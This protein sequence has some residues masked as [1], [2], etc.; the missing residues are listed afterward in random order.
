VAGRGRGDGSAAG[1]VS[2]VG[3][4]VI[5][6][7]E[8]F[9][10]PELA[11][12]E[13]TYHKAPWVEG[14][15]DLGDM[16]LKRMDEAG[17]DL[18]VIS[19]APPAAQNLPPEQSVAA[20]RRANDMLHEAVKAHPK[21]FAGFAALPTPD[22]KAAADE[23]E[24]CV[25]K[26]GFKGAMTHGLTHGAFI[27][28][29]RFWPIFERAEALGVP[30]YLH[31]AIP[32]P[33]I[34]EIY[35]KDYPQMSRGAWGFTME[36]ATAAMRLIL[37]GVFDAYPKLQCILGHLGETVPFNLWRADGVLGVPKGLKKRYREYFCEHFHITTS[38][39]Y[40]W[41]AFQCCMLEMGVERI[42][43]AVDYPYASN[44]DARKCFDAF[45]ISAADKDR[46]LHGNAEALLK[47]R[48]Q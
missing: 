11:L 8:H 16:R 4:T 33:K 31:P 19:H 3:V 36:T 1:N 13:D 34:L 12:S 20:S 42:M 22:P 17:I 40:S 39:N 38:G 25:T 28:E 23:L 32:H 45:P 21:R 47:L 30:V 43:F 26:L 44:T 7:E 27:D 15:G 35:F 37:S 6:I 14:L 10:T 5:A 2:G 9:W 18:Q 41:P 46:I 24:R 29:K 48:S